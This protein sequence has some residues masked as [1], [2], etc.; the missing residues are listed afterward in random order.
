[1]FPPS[2]QRRIRQDLTAGYDVRMVRK[3]TSGMKE[4]GCAVLVSIIKRNGKK[5][6]NDESNFLKLHGN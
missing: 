1:M 4:P 5:V 6:K 2:F 3:M